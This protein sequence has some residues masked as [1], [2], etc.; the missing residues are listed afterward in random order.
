MSACCRQ[1]P[2]RSERTEIARYL[3]PRRRPSPGYRWV[4][5]C[6]TS[7]GRVEDWRAGVGRSLCSLFLALSVTRVSQHLDHATYPAPAT[8]NAACGFPRTALPCS[9]LA[10]GYETGTARVAFGTKYRTL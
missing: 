9:F 6:I 2:G 3:F 1:Y 7:F 8:S 4:S 10:K 5:T